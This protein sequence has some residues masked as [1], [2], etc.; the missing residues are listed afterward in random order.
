MGASES[1]KRSEVN[2]GVLSLATEKFKQM[3][4][5]IEELKKFS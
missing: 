3:E 5:E 1:I 2:G 4:T